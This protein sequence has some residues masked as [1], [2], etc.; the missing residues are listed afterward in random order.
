MK[1]SSNSSKPLFS[2]I[3]SQKKSSG[4]RNRPVSERNAKKEAQ[5]VD[6]PLYF[7]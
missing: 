2:D 4:K 7:E 6:L 3:V 1:N 5:K